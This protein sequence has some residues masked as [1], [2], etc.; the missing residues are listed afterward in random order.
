VTER[1]IAAVIL[2][3]YPAKGESTSKE[4]VKKVDVHSKMYRLL[5]RDGLRLFKA[6]IT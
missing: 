6:A 4:K 5:G 2:I 1:D 3:L